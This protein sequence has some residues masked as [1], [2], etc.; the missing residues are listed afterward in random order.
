M[1]KDILRNT[2]RKPGLTLIEVIISV[3]LLAILSVPI[4][5]TVN[6]NV[7]MSQKTELSQ[8]A[9]VIGQ[10]V[11]EY[12]GTVNEIELG[13]DSVLDSIG[14]QL[15]FSK[16]INS[17][18]FVASGK[19]KQ[20]FDI[21][22]NLRNLIENDDQTSDSTS[23]ELM[24]QLQFEIL[25][26][27]NQLVVNREPILG[28][29]ILEVT[30]QSIQFCGEVSLE[31]SSKEVSCVNAKSSVLNVNE[32]TGN[33]ESITIGVNG[34]VDDT[35]EVLVDNNTNA[36]IKVYVQFEANQRKN[37]KFKKQIGQVDVIY[38]TKQ[39]DLDFDSEESNVESIVDLYE[40]SVEITSSK[41]DGFLFKGNTVSNLN[42]FATGQEGN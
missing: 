7:K 10:R 18:F 20:N 34:I 30:D 8:Q 6:T 26:F 33:V 9:T 31:E 21:E 23:N 35:Y 28:D 38:L 11:L 42:I 25:E 4:F 13:D 24:K 32:S 29:L 37:V 1:M 15:A 36:L 39:L 3:A 40:I 27:N 16:D 2:K 17:D 12:L 22:V 41:V 14:L 19:T 5:I